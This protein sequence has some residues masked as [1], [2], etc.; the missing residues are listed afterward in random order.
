MT[1]MYQEPRI[2]ARRVTAALATI[3]ALLSGL[4]TST[5]HA[6]QADK[7]K[8]LVYSADHLSY[9]D[10]KQTTI[11]TG[12]VELTKGTIIV[13]GDRAEIHQDPEGYSY[14]TA[15]SDKGLAYIREKRDGVNEYFEGQ[16]KRIDYDGK[17]DVSTL[18]GQAVARRLS[19]L[20]TP[21]DEV[22]GSVIRYDGQTG[23]YTAQS[24]GGTKTGTP[25]G[26]VRGMI[27]P[28]T[29]TSGGAVLTPSDS[30][31]VTPPPATTGK[32]RSNLSPAA[33]DGASTTSGATPLE[34]AR[35]LEDAQ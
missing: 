3:T 28:T 5:V 26:R 21:I 20:T 31:D 12:N 6:E 13:R 34:P 19:G 25:G 10:L 27:A 2:L 32:A 7:N 24:N 29:N 33:T 18:T 1:F 17:N 16:G 22:H 9:D 15:T 23:Y 8:P 11:L 35:Q 4:I 14:A 30:S